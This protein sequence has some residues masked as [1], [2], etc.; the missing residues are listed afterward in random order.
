[1]SQRRF[2][3]INLQLIA[4][5]KA[6]QERDLLQNHLEQ[7]RKDLAKAWAEETGLSQQLEL[8]QQ[9]VDELS[10][11]SLASRMLNVIGKRDAIFAK[12]E[13]A[14]NELQRAYRASHKL[15]A[16]LERQQAIW[17]SDLDALT[18]YA[19]QFNDLKAQQIGLI[20]TLDTSDPLRDLLAELEQKDAQKRELEYL[21]DKCQVALN[22][23]GRLVT[24]PRD[25]R[26]VF[27]NK[28]SEIITALRL[29]YETLNEHKRPFWIPPINPFSYLVGMDTYAGLHNLMAHLDDLRA[30]VENHLHTFRQELAPIQETYDDLLL[31]KQATIK[32]LWR[33]ENFA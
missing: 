21:I 28:L 1:M 22:A 31:E 11:P 8:K 9:D 33:E 29:L 24:F 18:P 6:Q 27:Q 25:S 12:E 5:Q 20:L 4:A 16:D 26:A 32:D 2:S 3:E 10:Q 15:V 23:F 19:E 17:Q 14:L 13:S 7:I 30:L